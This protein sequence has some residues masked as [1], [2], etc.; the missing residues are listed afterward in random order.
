M[1]NWGKENTKKM[2]NSMES[3]SV[4]FVENKSS[5]DIR[6]P[7]DC[8]EMHYGM[9]AGKLRDQ[10]VGRKVGNILG[11]INTPSHDSSS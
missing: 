1:G 7:V 10:C 5:E 6:L 9:N 4:S 2:G 8:S 11:G 3:R